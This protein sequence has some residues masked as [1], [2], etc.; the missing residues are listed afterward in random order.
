VVKKIEVYDPAMC[1]SSGLCGPAPN[2]ELTRVAADL[3]RLAK[4]GV[5]VRRYGLSQEP[6]AFLSQEDVKR[7]LL[8]KGQDILPLT[9]VDGQV[10][11]TE[12]Y[13]TTVEFETWLDAARENA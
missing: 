2:K 5:E 1:C 6:A 7:L 11:L 13:P 4:R 8:E 12:R 3:K 9:V 10:R